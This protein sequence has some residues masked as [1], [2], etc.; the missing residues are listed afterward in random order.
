M[1]IL[2]SGVCL[3]TVYEGTQLLLST[4]VIFRA[5]KL[6]RIRLTGQMERAGETEVLIGQPEEKWPLGDTQT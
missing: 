2:K 6:R 5:F 3:K 4:N 1:H